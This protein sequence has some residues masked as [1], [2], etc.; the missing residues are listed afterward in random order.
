MLYKEPVKVYA[1]IASLYASINHDEEL[2]NLAIEFVV[3]KS[4]KPTLDWEKIYLAVVE[5]YD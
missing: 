5:R 2:Y 3:N 1:C 4:D